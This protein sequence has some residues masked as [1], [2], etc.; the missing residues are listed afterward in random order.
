M[1]TL[2]P[3][4]SPS[5]QALKFSCQAVKLVGLGKFGAIPVLYSCP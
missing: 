1:D 4:Q 3:A 5:A 2:P